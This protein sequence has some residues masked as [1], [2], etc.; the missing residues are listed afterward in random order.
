MVSDYWCLVAT[1]VPVAGAQQE[2]ARVT[3]APVVPD[4]TAPD[5]ASD[6]QS[7]GVAGEDGVQPGTEPE[8]TLASSF[9]T[10]R[11]GGPS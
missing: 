9:R 5:E 11:P 1:Y 2:E 3:G 6:S 8:H 10:L 4:V 7:R